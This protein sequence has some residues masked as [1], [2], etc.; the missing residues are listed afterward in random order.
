MSEVTVPEII[1]ALEVVHDRLGRTNPEFNLHGCL[2]Q[3]RGHLRDVLRLALGGLPD[4]AV[5][6]E[7]PYSEVCMHM[8]VA[9]KLMWGVPN[10]WK[11][12]TTEEQEGVRNIQLHRLDGSRFTTGPITIGEAGWTLT[13]CRV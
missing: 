3:V 11:N 1:T 2:R 8:R 9:G 10:Y 6:L 7:L 13:G 12:P 5:L 4:D